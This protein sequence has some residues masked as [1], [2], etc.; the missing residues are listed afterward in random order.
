MQVS[1]CLESFSFIIC[2]EI[3]NYI[4]FSFVLFQYHFAYCGS[5]KFHIIFRIKLFNSENFLKR[6]CN[7]KGVAILTILSSINMDVFQLLILFLI[8]YNNV[9]AFRIQLSHFFVNFIKCF[10]LIQIKI[11]TLFLDISFL[12]Y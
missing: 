2:F 4:S 5:L 10:F 8:T 12:V 7:L 6:I 1:H 11:F 3:W 9:L